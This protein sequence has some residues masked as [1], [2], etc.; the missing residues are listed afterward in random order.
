MTRRGGIHQ[1]TTSS[2]FIVSIARARPSRWRNE[3]IGRSFL[4]PA[5]SN[6]TR[7]K[8]CPVRAVI[9]E[10]LRGASLTTADLAAAGITNQRETTLLWIAN[11]RAVHNALVS[12]DT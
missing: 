3:S 7:R 8:S 9:E 4:S 1:G 12:Q 6:M 5:G 10:A 11:R 2:R